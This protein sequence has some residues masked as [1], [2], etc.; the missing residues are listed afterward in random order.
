MLNPVRFDSAL[1]ECIHV[2]LAALLNGIYATQVKELIDFY[3]N[4]VVDKA[5][6]TAYKVYARI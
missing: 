4:D 2:I 3:G 6:E 1:S 5:Y